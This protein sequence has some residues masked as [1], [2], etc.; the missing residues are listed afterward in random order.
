MRQALI[1]SGQAGPRVQGLL[2]SEERGELNRRLRNE[3]RKL[4]RQKVFVRLGAAHFG[5]DLLPPLCFARSMNSQ[6]A[7]FA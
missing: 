1:D 3:N 7:R 6:G 2:T 4:R 5:K